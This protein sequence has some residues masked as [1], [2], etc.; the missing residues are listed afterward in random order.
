M[1]TRSRNNR[2]SSECVCAP[3]RRRTRL[4]A[5]SL[6]VVSL[7]GV[8]A[9]SGEAPVDTTV[10]SAEGLA[11]VLTQQDPER[12]S[13]ATEVELGDDPSSA[14]DLEEMEVDGSEVIAKAVRSKTF[15][16]PTVN[17]KHIRFTGSSEYQYCKARGIDGG[18]SSGLM[19]RIAGHN[20]IAEW[21]S[22]DGGWFFYT[23]DVA[24]ID[25]WPVIHKVVCIY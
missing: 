6:V 10:L 14:G 20:T 24:P 18:L 4:A 22:W 2:P 23:D 13:F 5:Q 19:K 21:D 1:W 7:M 3:A 15:W 16:N 9:C 11:G 8:L 12:S 25:P 17:G